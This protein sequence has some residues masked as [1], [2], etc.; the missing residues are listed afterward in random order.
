MRGHLVDGED[1]TDPGGDLH[2][3]G[4]VGNL[5]GQV[6]GKEA[7]RSGGLVHREGLSA[8]SVRPLCSV[9]RGQREPA[10]QMCCYMVLKLQL[11]PQGSR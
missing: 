2:R 1:I 4:E 8:G 9:S 11:P 3:G 5:W 7:G 6:S 10:F